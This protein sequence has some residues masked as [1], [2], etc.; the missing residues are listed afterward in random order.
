MAEP[1][2]PATTE[3]ERIVGAAPAGAHDQE[4]AAAAVRDMFTSIAPRY[5]L[6]NHVLSMNID[7]VWWNRTARTFAEV[8][9]P[10][11]TRRYSI[12]A[13]ALAT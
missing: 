12:C 11:Q 10:I 5:D 9:A 3:A 13:A 2:Q 4:A 1:N 8:S 6:L 7:R